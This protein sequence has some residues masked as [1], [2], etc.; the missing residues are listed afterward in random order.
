MQTAAK[1]LRSEHPVAFQIPAP[2]KRRDGLETA[3]DKTKEA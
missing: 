1:A 3:G 2:A